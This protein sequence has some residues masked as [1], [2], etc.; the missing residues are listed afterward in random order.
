MKA[1]LFGMVIIG[2]A[3]IAVLP[4][5]LGW[6]VS[7]YAFLRGV[8]PVLACFIGMVS[9]FIGIADIKDR[10]ELKKEKKAE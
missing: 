7:V 9:I 1:L 2:L 6:W 8:L 10:A 4:A 3:V 5:G